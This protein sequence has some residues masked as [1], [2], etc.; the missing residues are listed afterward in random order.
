[1][2][3]PF[4][5][6]FRW[7]A[8][9]ALSLCSIG[10]LLALM[11]VSTAALRPVQRALPKAKKQ[12]AHP[13]TPAGWSLVTG[14]NLNDG[15]KNNVLSGLDCS[16]PSDC[17][18]VGTY[19]TNSG[20]QG[21]IEHW[22][23]TS[24]AIVMFPSDTAHSGFNDVTCNSASDCWAVGNDDSG[25]LI[26]HWS[27]TSWSKV[28]S[29]DGTHAATG[30]AVAC[31]SS[32]DCWVAGS[33]YTGTVSQT[34]IE[35]WNGATWTPVASPNV[36]T[37]S[38]N[39]LT[40]ISCTAG[41]D[42]WAAGYHWTGSASQTLIEHWNGTN[43]SIVGSPNTGSD[44][45]NY[46]H[47]VACNSSS[48]CWAVG[49]AYSDLDY[50]QELILHWN[51]IVWAVSPS[52]ST[53]TANRNELFGLVCNSSADCWATGE[54]YALQA[55]RIVHWNGTVWSVV[56]SPDRYQYD[57]DILLGVNCN[58]ASDCWAV[59][60][61]GSTNR[62]LAEHW[63]GNSWALVSSPNI[64]TGYRPNGLS[65]VTCLTESDCWVV[66]THNEGNNTGD[67]PQT[68][69]GHWNGSE[70]RVVPSANDLTTGEGL[71]E[72]VT[73]AASNDCWAVGYVGNYIGS[74]VMV[75]HWTGGPEWLLV[76][77]PN[78]A[79]TQNR[80]HS[81]ACTSSSDCWAVG[82]SNPTNNG[83]DW[84]TFIEH[85]NGIAWTI[86]PSPITGNGDHLAAVTCVTSDNCWA[87]GYTISLSAYHDRSLIE[88]WNG[89]TWTIVSSPNSSDTESNYLQSVTCISASDCWAVGSS[90]S[91]GGPGS[92]T[93]IEHWNG[94]AWLII[95][96]SD[97]SN[98]W[99][100]LYSVAC[101]SSSNC[102]SV[103]E[104]YRTSNGGYATLIENWNGLIWQVVD[105]P[106]PAAYFNQ[107][108]GVVC[109]SA[110]SCWAAGSQFPAPGAVG[111]QT[112][113]EHYTAY[114]PLLKITAITRL[115]NGHMMISG[116]SDPL[117]SLQIQASPDLVAP[118]A[119]IGSTTSD[120]TGAFQ[121][122][123]VDA[124]TFTKRFYRAAYP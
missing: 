20:N 107:L 7:R 82:D 41:N 87:V 69:T 115:T 13:S 63:N 89:S 95:A 11:S 124:A 6:V 94:V 12:L 81:V 83:T 76:S 23:G 28:D 86:T 84:K 98:S 18:A 49:G 43:W 5:T 101:S 42:C 4:M 14:P 111:W 114:V 15:P 34:F 113:I 31:N 39:I 121:F 51:G 68:L 123:D 99:H 40:A 106:S 120:P 33:Y 85:W 96:S 79:A 16:S 9:I 71:L 105:S 91:G 2:S 45:D 119:K 109:P 62:T 64:D 116:T 77:A 110:A 22:N 65:A 59:G 1:M 104:Y 53:G 37:T 55:T 122:E 78:A 88:H 102:W 100:A 54:D 32:T 19:Q 97:A 57:D 56:N 80:L 24:W 44:R 52:P 47:D 61:S 66:G 75:E 112:L 30:N 67:T 29:H 46:L 17:W 73:C 92:R 36:E 3:I 72:G 74:Q 108:Y 21:L 58:S 60:Y 103:G 50:F 48:D 10:M 70:W 35:H 90:R 38:D 93:L 8:V 26:E 25:A 118:F 117:L 27:R